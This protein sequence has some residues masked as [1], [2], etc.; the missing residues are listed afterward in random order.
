[1]TYDQANTIGEAIT[2]AI[3]TLPGSS[4]QATENIRETIRSDALSLQG[5]LLGLMQVANVSALATAGAAADAILT[6]GASTNSNLRND[7]IDANTAYLPLRTLYQQVMSWIRG[8]QATEYKSVFTPVSGAGSPEVV[9]AILVGY[10]ATYQTL[11]G[12]T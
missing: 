5:G 12:A 8:T 10:L 11:T 7:C 6:Y 3:A 1:M 2:A 9:A 4:I